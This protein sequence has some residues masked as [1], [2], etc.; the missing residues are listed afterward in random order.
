[1]I[2]T[3]KNLHVEAQL[4]VNFRGGW[5]ALVYHT[6]VSLCSLCSLNGPGWGGQRGR[7]GEGVG[8][9]VR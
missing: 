9:G 4:G 8:G 1:M 3:E 5:M 7:V 6:A 2:Y